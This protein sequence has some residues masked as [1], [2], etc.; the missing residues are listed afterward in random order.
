MPKRKRKHTT[1]TGGGQKQQ[2]V[3]LQGVAFGFLCSP[4][5]FPLSVLLQP[6]ERRTGPGQAFQRRSALRPGLRW[7]KGRVIDLI[8]YENEK[9]HADNDAGREMSNNI[10]KN[11]TL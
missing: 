8:D 1:A 2:R 4:F 7:L 10:I 11:A 9:L 6:S 3:N 5:A